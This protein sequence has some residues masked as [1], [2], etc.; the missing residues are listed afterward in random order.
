MY[1]SHKPSNISK[2]GFIHL[3]MLVLFLMPASRRI[4]ASEKTPN[5]SGA[6]LLVLEDCDS[7]NKLS[8]E[9]YGDTASLLNSKGQIIRKFHGLMIKNTFWRFQ[10]CFSVGGWPFICSV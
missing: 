1:N 4:F 3:L 6:M 2:H 7:D 8:T 10:E 5:E 9:P